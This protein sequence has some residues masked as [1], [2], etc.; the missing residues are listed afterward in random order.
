M[1]N[2]ISTFASAFGMR[3]NKFPFFSNSSDAN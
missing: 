3:G 2:E 1:M